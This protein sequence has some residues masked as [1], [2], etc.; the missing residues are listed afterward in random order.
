M[1]VNTNV[2]R[3]FEVVRL[4]VIMRTTC[5]SESVFEFSGSSH[6]HKRS[7]T[8]RQIQGSGWEKQ[9]C[10]F[11]QTRCR[12]LF[13][14]CAHHTGRRSSRRGLQLEN[15]SK[16]LCLQT[17]HKKMTRNLLHKNKSKFSRFKSRAYRLPKLIFREQKQQQTHGYVVRIFGLALS[18][19][20]TP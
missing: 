3:P 18:A 12:Q 7:N 1:F 6:N 5:L 8:S 9:I 4:P 16:R 11:C 14:H 17:F 2:W 19:M 10:R 20:L 13:R 15:E